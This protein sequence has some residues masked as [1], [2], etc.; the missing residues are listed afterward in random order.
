MFIWALVAWGSTDESLIFGGS[1][2]GALSGLVIQFLVR[3]PD[4]YRKFG[5][6]LVSHSRFIDILLP[7]VATIYGPRDMANV[8]MISIPGIIFESLSTRNAR[9]GHV[10]LR[11]RFCVHLLRS[12]FKRDVAIAI[13][14]GIWDCLCGI[15]WNHFGSVPSEGP[16][17]PRSRSATVDLDEYVFERR[18]VG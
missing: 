14:V 17:S 2:F 11:G 15:R 6:Q 16:R 9:R 13:G 5:K 7:L 1:L 10:D 18:C 8:W 12:G 4:A 3:K